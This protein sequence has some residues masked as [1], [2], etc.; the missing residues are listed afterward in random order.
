[1]RLVAVADEG[2]GELAIRIVLAA[3]QG[4]AKHFGI[5]GDG[6]VQVADTQHGMQQS[7]RC[8]LIGCP[9]SRAINTN[10]GSWPGFVGSCGQAY[11]NSLRPLPAAMRMRRALSLMKPAASAWL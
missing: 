6:F 10:P 5:E 11:Q 8:F 2:Q 9:L 3:Q 7:H 1:M 4:H